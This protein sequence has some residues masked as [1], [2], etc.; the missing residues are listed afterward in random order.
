MIR[1]GYDSFMPITESIDEIDIFERYVIKAH[2][3]K[4][5]TLIALYIL[6]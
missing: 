4:Y 5:V 1:D 2:R 3:K 6:N